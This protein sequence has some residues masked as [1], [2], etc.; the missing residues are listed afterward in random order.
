MVRI[1]RGIKGRAWAGV[2]ASALVL[3]CGGGGDD[4]P[5]G[6]TGNIQVSINPATLTVQQGGT[7]SVTATLTRG[8]GFDGAVTLAITGLPAGVTTTI[9]PAQL[10]GATTSATVDVA[11]AASV[12]P[13]TYTATVNATAQGIG[14]AS[15]TYQLTVTGTPN[16]ALTMAPTQ[17]SVEQGKSNTATVNINRTNFTGA[18]ALSLV[19][20]PAGITGTF[21]P[22]SSTTNA[23]TLT[24]AVDAAVAPGNHTLT[25]QGDATGPGTKTTTLALTVTAPAPPSYTL[26]LDPTTISIATG[27]SGSV[28]VVLGRTNFAEAIALTV[29]GAP[30]GITAAV[31]PASATGNAAVVNITVAADA[32]PGNHQLTVRGT[33]NGLTDRTASL[34][35]TVTAPSSIALTLAPQTVSIQQGQNANVTVNIA[36]TN[37]TG[38]VTLAAS[39]GAGLTYTFNPNNT[40]T[41]SSTLNI[42]VAGNATAGVQQITVTGTGTGVTN[43]TAQLSVNVSVPGS[44]G[45]SEY[46]FCSASETPIFFAVQD[47]TGPW[48][49]VTGTTVGTTTKFA[50]NITANRGGVMYVFRTQSSLV[51]DASSVSHSGNRLLEAKRLM[52]QNRR[53]QERARDAGR[54]RSFA[55]S[56]MI[57]LYQTHVLYGTAAELKQLGTDNCFLTSGSKS[58]NGTVA[59][60]GAGQSAVISMDESV[61]TF[62]GGFSTNPVTFEGVPN[63]TVDLVGTRSPQIFGAP[64]KLVLFRNL[65]VPD[66]GT[67]PSTIDFDGPASSVPA[68][69]A[70]T[71]ANTGGL[72]VVM[73][74]QLLT[75]NGST[76]SLYYD[77]GGS[78]TTRTWS[79]LDQSRM[80]AGDIHGLYAFA[81][82]TANPT[83]ESKAL[84]QYVGPVAAQTL[85]FGP[86]MPNA[87]ITAVSGAPYP[88]YRVQGTLPTEYPQGVSLTLVNMAGAGNL[89]SITATAAYLAA[90]GSASAYDVTMPDVAGLAGFPAA[91]RLNAGQTLVTYTGYG[92]T[93]SGIMFLEPTIG[94]KMQMASKGATINVP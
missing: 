70:L 18:V 68:T 71:L 39:A 38:N 35:V 43:A 25:I 76:M 47:G 1:S 90:A 63:R 49:A 62:L 8:G 78:G 40:N 48:Q 61:V 46:E 27:A 51:A 66:G 26:T 52:D 34:T 94:D 53:A 54:G 42:A 50:F 67:L 15:T 82:P 31:A 23:S 21:N 59:G 11:V 32:A 65:N 75:A 56:S 7:G 41:N 81:I 9:N 60:V 77:I 33:A 91:S 88:R 92:W 20:P 80:I 6:P 4:G 22:A 30:Q 55:R 83:S 85:T 86:S 12:A 2:L 24:V 10:T 72:D 37:F 57:D 69:A 36:R 64:D 58:V 16:Y 29:E 28:D 74:S 89:F 44:G 13:G 73:T 3:A 79:G 5:S 17:L 84:F 87:T 19:N 14:S 93:G 45:N